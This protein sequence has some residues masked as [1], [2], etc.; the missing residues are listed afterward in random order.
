[1]RTRSLPG[2]FS[3]QPN[4]NLLPA[5]RCLRCYYLKVWIPPN[6]S[7]QKV[8][9]HAP[10]NR[11]ASEETLTL[12]LCPTAC[13]DNQL[14]LFLLDEWSARHLAPPGERWVLVP[15]TP[16]VPCEG[17]HRLQPPLTH[18]MVWPE[19]T[20]KDSPRSWCRW[21]LRCHP[22]GSGKGQSQTLCTPGYCWP[23]CSSQPGPGARSSSQPGT[24]CPQRCPWASPPAG[25]P[26]TVHHFAVR[27]HQEHPDQDGVVVLQSPGTGAPPPV[28]SWPSCSLPPPTPILIPPL[29]C[30]SL[31]SLP[32]LV[33][34]ISKLPLKATHFSPP[35]LPPF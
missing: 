15:V 28:T 4:Q 31:F 29:E 22:G 1:M 18:V 2:D 14:L 27:R 24:S 12:T 20:Q 19:K 30:S 16:R 26:W 32:S 5:Y 23:E 33:T 6:H 11:M 3:A 34:L 25:S 13:L 35:P 9:S 17:S 7:F 10:R 21:G 8:L